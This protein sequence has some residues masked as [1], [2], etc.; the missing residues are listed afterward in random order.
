MQLHDTNPP[1]LEQ[2]IVPDEIVVR[3]NG[4]THRLPYHLGDTLLETIRREGVPIPS[5]CV[6]GVCATCMVRR[7]QG[8]VMLRE[9]HVLSEED[10]AAGYTLA[11]QG[12]PRGTVC[13]IEIEG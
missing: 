11:C 8:E 1:D 3:Q 13:E 5:A 7:I 4:R 10:L 2:P 6:Q 9:N 12:E